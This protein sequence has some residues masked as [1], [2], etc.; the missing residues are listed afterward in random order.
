MCIS[1]IAHVRA[2]CMCLKLNAVP[3]LKSCGPRCSLRARASPINLCGPLP[4]NGDTRSH[5]RR[6]AM[7][8]CGDAAIPKHRRRY[9]AYIRC[10]LACARGAH[11]YFHTAREC[12]APLR[13]VHIEYTHTIVVTRIYWELGTSILG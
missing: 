6:V 2:Q 12:V 11:P 10:R 5:K 4:S 7:A 13:I 8:Q 9:I 1:L 3:S